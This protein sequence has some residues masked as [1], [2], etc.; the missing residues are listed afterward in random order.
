M[1]SPRQIMQFIESNDLG[2]TLGNAVRAIIYACQ[3]EFGKA[4]AEANPELTRHKRLQHLKDARLFLNVE[5][6][7]L[8]KKEKE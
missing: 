2:Y 4:M 6:K 5:I 1:N 3:P 7:R 8:S